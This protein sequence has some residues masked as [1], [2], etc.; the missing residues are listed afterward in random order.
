M[1]VC[2]MASARA[3]I[4][5]PLRNDLLSRPSAR[6]AAFQSLTTVAHAEVAHTNAATKVVTLISRRT[7]MVFS[8]GIRP[9]VKEHLSRRQQAPTRC[10]ASTRPATARYIM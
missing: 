8:N 3:T 7:T 5:G 6:A 9:R 10:G 4:G 1:H 2:A